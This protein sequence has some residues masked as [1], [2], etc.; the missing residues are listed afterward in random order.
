MPMRSRSVALFVVVVSSLVP[1]W[2]RKA[3][4]PAGCASSR[5]R[6]LRAPAWSVLM[7]AGAAHG[8]QVCSAEDAVRARSAVHAYWAGNSLAP[9]PPRTRKRSLQQ[10][11]ARLRT[12]QQCTKQEC[13]AGTC[14]MV[15]NEAKKDDFRR[16]QGRHRHV[17][18]EGSTSLCV[19]HSCSI[20]GL[21]SCAEDSEMH[22]ESELRNIPTVLCRAPQTLRVCNSNAPLSCV[23]RSH[24]ESR[25]ETW[26]ACSVAMGPRNLAVM[27]VSCGDTSGDTS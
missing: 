26:P 15:V 27:F 12:C 25:Q 11:R 21:G 8:A 24:A 23:A 3:R 22:P 19:N 20:N 5:N 18:T 9:L 7:S 1:C 17:R 13:F 4:S 16:Q 6:M 14:C 10:A 2:S